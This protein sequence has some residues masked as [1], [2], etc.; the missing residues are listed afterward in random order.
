[1]KKKILSLLTAFAMVFGIIAAPFTSASAAQT[2]EKTNT[3]TLHKLLMTKE[4]LKAWDSG[5]VEE[6]TDT[7]AG[8]DGTQDLAGLNAILKAIDTKNEEVKEI[9]GVYFAWQ[10]KDT[11]GTWKYI[12]AQGEIIANQPTKNTKEAFDQAGVFGKLTEAT[13]AVFTTTPLKQEKSG[14][15]YRIVEVKE[16]STY[17]NNDGSI[18]TDSKAVPV[19]ITLPLVNSKGVQSSVHVYPKNTE[20]KPEIDKN[21][22]TETN[23]EAT[24]ITENDIVSDTKDL[25]IDTK[26]SNRDK[27]TATKKVNDNVPFKVE[28]VIPA[29][30]EYKNISW[31]D[32]MTNGLTFNKDLTFTAT[33]GTNQTLELGTN[34][35]K[36]TQ[37]D[38]GFKLS[39]TTTGLNKVSTIT[40]PKDANDVSTNAGQDV[41]FTLKYTAKVNS[42][43]VADVEDKNDITLEYG[44]KPGKEIEEKDVKSK[45]K[46]LQVTKNWADGDNTNAPDG[47]SVTYTLKDGD[48]VV[49]SVGL[50]GTETVGTKYNVGT[51]ITF[52]VTGKYAGKFVGL[53]D[54]K[55]YKISERVSGYAPE[56][57]AQ[58][59]DGTVTITNN[60]DNDNPP[61]LNPS[62]PKV[63]TY[64]KKFVKTDSTDESKRL[65]GA[66]FVVKNA[67]GQYL[68]AKD[69]QSTT[70]DKT[71]F[72]TADEAYHKAIE[73]YNKAIAAEGAT[74]ESVSITIGET[75]YTGKNAIMAQIEKLKE[76]RDAKFKEA[77]NQY[78]WKTLDTAPTEQNTQGALVLTSNN[79]GQ[80]EIDGLAAGTYRLEEIKAPEGF[81]KLD[82]SEKQLEFTVGAG[83]YNGT[84]QE[85]NY[86]VELKDGETQTYGQ[87]IKNKKVTIPQTGGIG[88]L[89]F[90]VAGLAIMAGAYVA[91]RKNQ[92]RA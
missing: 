85:F 31:N 6:G 52:E 17:K 32:S 69:P 48:N 38:R 4:Q 7:T 70:T 5:K 66:K 79:E 39:L 86:E 11:D 78:N 8:Y 22:D 51:G 13:G 26:D 41:K 10:A 28:T 44:N 35:Y 81:A 23:G 9:A 83:T 59:T 2:E 55:T 88:S 75:P 57:Q 89:I 84:A 36:L 92:A 30:S 40:K 45:D 77:K 46:T 15:Q 27:S 49:A 14:T 29:G 24:G 72:E 73:D 71:A 91:Y 90:V 42:N 19:Y 1:M 47:V 80:F 58:N 74:E 87:Q 76:D 56:Y 54:T 67:Q 82:A 53:D 62:E 3:V 43:A 16:L 37:D 12:N 60:K 25:K 21:F 18:L 68:F 33:Y 64:G 34:D 50:N 63:V 20:E 61:P 65:A